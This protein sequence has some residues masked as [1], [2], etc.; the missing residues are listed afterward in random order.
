MLTLASYD[1][2]TQTRKNFGAGVGRFLESFY[3]NSKSYTQ[4]QPSA[5]RRGEARPSAPTAREPAPS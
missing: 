4:P 1:A 2:I 5:S 3:T